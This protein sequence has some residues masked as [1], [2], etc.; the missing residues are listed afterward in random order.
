[1][2]EDRKIKPL[3]GMPPND[4]EEENRAWQKLNERRRQLA[5]PAYNSKTSPTKH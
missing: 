4:E 3:T 2:S 5:G 1:M